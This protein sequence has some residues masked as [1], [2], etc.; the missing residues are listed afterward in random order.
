MIHIC[1]PKDKAPGPSINTTSRDKDW[2]QGLSPFYL[3]PVK[4]YGNYVAKNVENAWQFSKVY[5]RHVKP[6]GEPDQSYFFWASKGW[7][8]D[9]AHR[10]PMGRGAKPEYSYWDG[11]KLNYIEA[12]KAIYAPLYAKAVEDTP[13]FTRLKEEAAKGDIWLWDFDGYDHRK[14]NM[15][16]KDVI[17][18]ETMKMGHAFVLAMMLENERVWE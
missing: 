13:A 6:D 18:C 2:S 7:S 12:R 10:Y 16:Y 8:D 5:D 9:F 4:L 14:R 11:K 3:G 15:T 17:N 1:G